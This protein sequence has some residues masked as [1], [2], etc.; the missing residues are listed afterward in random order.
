MN[1]K[2]SVLAICT[3]AIIYLLL[4]N[5]LHCT[6]NGVRMNDINAYTTRESRKSKVSHLVF[7]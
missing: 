1:V 2:I 3:E 6:F 5:L 4:S 7:L